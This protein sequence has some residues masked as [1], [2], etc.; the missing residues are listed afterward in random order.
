MKAK[1]P[2]VPEILFVEDGFSGGLIWL[3]GVICSSMR[4]RIAV[5]RDET[6]ALAYLLD[7]EKPRPEVIVLENTP[8]KF[9]GEE[10]LNRLRANERTR[11]V[12]VILF[13]GS[14]PGDRPACSVD[15]A[16]GLKCATAADRHRRAE[17]VIDGGLTAI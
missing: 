5:R 4:C 3:E 17:L 7:S 16:E 10:L 6:G 14:A 11:T 9:S 13:N 2:P 8:P 15:L 12:P 1:A